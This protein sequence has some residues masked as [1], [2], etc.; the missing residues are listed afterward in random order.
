MMLR[1][2]SRSLA[3]VFVRCGTPRCG[4]C[5]A[6]LSPIKSRFCVMLALAALAPMSSRFWLCPK[7]VGLLRLPVLDV[8][9]LC[10]Y[11]LLVVR[12]VA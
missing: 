5:D 8:V 2:K 9:R 7:A 1:R 11:S 10:V 3:V 12:C 4:G 6:E